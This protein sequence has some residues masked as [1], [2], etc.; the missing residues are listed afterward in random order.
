MAVERDWVR[1]RVTVPLRDHVDVG[2]MV[3]DWDRVEVREGV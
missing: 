1:G 2:R 3:A